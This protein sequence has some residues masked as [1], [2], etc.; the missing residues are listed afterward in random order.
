MR[1]N[2][3]CKKLKSTQNNSQLQ[4]AQLKVLQRDNTHIAKINSEAIEKAGAVI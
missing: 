2:E 3:T 1:L 4:N